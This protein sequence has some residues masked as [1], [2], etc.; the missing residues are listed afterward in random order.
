MEEVGELTEKKKFMAFLTRE[1]Q[2]TD[3]QTS[4]L[5]PWLPRQPDEKPNSSV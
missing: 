3:R 1:R 4:S 2:N 5:I